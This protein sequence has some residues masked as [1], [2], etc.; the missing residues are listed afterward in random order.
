MSVGTN[1][2]FICKFK[3]KPA[4]RIK[5][6]FIKITFKNPFVVPLH[7]FGHQNK[8]LNLTIPPKVS[9]KALLLSSLCNHTY[10]IHQLVNLCTR[11]EAI[12]IFAVETESSFF[13]HSHPFNE[14][15]KCRCHHYVKPLH[16]FLH[17]VPQERCHVFHF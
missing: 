2:I 10:S 1:T 4:V 8:A 9:C 12:T 17:M 14:T 15:W 13:S 11:R 5:Y 7:D 16:T 6:C 3:Q